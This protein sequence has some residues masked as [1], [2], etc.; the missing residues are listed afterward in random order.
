MYFKHPN[1]DS[2]VCKADFVVC[3]S[4]LG[5]EDKNILQKILLKLGGSLKSNWD[6]ECTHLTMNQVSLTHKVRLSFKPLLHQNM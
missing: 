2:R 3:T 6:K 1:M 4:T 5:V